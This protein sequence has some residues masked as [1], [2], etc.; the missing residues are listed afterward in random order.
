MSANSLI[1]EIGNLPNSQ[2]TYPSPLVAFNLQIAGNSNE[3]IIPKNEL[4]RVKEILQQNE[5]SV[6]VRRS[7]NGKKQS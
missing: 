4:S 1:K 6:L 5:Y 3:A 2:F 7:Q